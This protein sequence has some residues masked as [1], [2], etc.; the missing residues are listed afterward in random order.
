MRL[1]RKGTSWWER[2]SL[3]SMNPWT[4][5]PSPE[6]LRSTSRLVEQGFSNHRKTLCNQELMIPRNGS[7]SSNSDNDGKILP[8]D[9]HRLEILCRI[10][11]SLSP[12]GKMLLR[13]ARRM[14]GL[15]SS[16]NL[17][18]DGIWIKAMR[19]TSPG[20]RG[21]VLVPSESGIRN[22]W[23]RNRWISQ[24]VDQESVDQNL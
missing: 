4:S 8:W 23:I 3:K 6:F 19:P 10:C 20:T 21:L 24:S 17:E 16:K 13:F 18:S 22:Q 15:T 1:R 5:H 9:G 7:L 12:L 14:A 2:L 11:A